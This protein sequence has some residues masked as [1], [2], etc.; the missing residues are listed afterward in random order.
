MRP[1]LEACTQKAEVSVDLLYFKAYSTIDEARDQ[2]SSSKTTENET[3]CT[4]Y[5]QMRYRYRRVANTPHSATLREISDEIYSD[6]RRKLSCVGH[7]VGR[8]DQEIAVYRC[9]FPFWA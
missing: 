3:A 2:I 4:S 1:A 7:F 6:R 9:Y 5:T 8:G